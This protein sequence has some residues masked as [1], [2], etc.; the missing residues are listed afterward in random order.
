MKEYVRAGHAH[1]IFDVSKT[2]FW[3]F[4]KLDG[5]PK[6]RVIFGIVLYSVAELKNWIDSTATQEVSA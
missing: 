1:E 5:F 3:R 4:S 2:S 6:K